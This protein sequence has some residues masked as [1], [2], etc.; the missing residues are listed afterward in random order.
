M[1]MYGKV[2]TFLS[3]KYILDQDKKDL[4]NFQSYFFASQW[5][6]VESTKLLM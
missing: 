4:H 5:G 6:K 1:H 3:Q 2:S